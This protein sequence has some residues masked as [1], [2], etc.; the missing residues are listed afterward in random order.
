MHATPLSCNSI[1]TALNYN[2]QTF[3]ILPLTNLEQRVPSQSPILRQAKWSPH[4]PEPANHRDARSTTR[5]TRCGREIDN[6]RST[7][8]LG[9]TI[10]KNGVNFSPHSSTTTGVDLLIFDEDDSPQP[11]QT[12]HF[13]QAKDYDWEGD[14]PLS[15]QGGIAPL[16]RGQIKLVLVLRC[17]PKS[18]LLVETKCRVEFHYS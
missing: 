3:Q 10:Q 14:K 13:V 1:R 17:D 18:V 12:I 4:N 15:V 6:L 16:F 9:A 2:R 7:H 11:V 5:S 8:P